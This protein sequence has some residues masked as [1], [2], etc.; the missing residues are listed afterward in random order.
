MSDIWNSVVGENYIQPIGGYGFRLV[1]SQETV[2]T[3]KIVSNLEK[4][5]ILEEMLDLES[6]PCCRDGT[7]H[8]HYLL[9]TPF[10]YPPLKHGSRFGGQFE[11]GLFYGGTSESVMLCESA[12]YRFYFY[13]DMEDPPEHEFIQSQHSLFKF[14]Y[15]SD[16]GTK[17]QESP[18]DFYEDTLR[19][20][21]N[22]KP[23][24]ELGSAM[25]KA[26][27]NGFE[28]RSA[29]DQSGGVNIALFNAS[30]LASRKPIDET[31]CLCQVSRKEV[32]F[33]IKRKITRFGIS[34]FLVNSLLPIPA[35]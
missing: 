17:L 20:P 10:R 26:N 22:Y 28:Y 12:F 27:L 29:R 18:F 35:D 32:V 2:A 8:L 33:S 30:S 1:E 9:S 5:S 15:K 31:S 3:M 6:K 16:L 13:N 24:Q 14:Q 11:P 34:Y 7:E 21:V 19:D 23:T 4:Q 25:R